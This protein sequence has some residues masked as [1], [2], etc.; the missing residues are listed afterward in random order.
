MFID[1]VPEA[2]AA[3][4][5]AEIYAEDRADLG[6]VPNYS[7]VFSHHPDAYMAWAGLSG[8]IRKQMDRRRYELATLAAARARRAN[9]C[10]VAHGKILRD[11]FHD[12]DTVVR[13]ATDHHRAD[14]DEVDVAIMDFA[15][16]VAREPTSVTQADVDRLRALGLAD[17]DVLDVVLTVA[18]RLFF[19]TTLEALGA[20]VDAALTDALE[21]ELVA[22]LLV[23][24]RPG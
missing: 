7:K 17:R 13:I 2:E 22:A 16:L 3:G 12:A 6:Y 10:A 24:P 1:P 19:A 5:I 21:P 9:Y 4:A 18:A 8:S 20:T 15:E 23:G 11:Q 14:L